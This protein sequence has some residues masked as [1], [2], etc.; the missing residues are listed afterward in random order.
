[1]TLRRRSQKPTREPTIALIN[2]VF[3]MLIFFLIA[4]TVAPPLDP[5]VSL[6]ETVELD[7]RAPPDAAVV[8]EDGTILRD[9]TQIPIEELASSGDVIRLVPDRDLAATALVA[10]SR[11]LR[12][13]GADEVWIVTERGLN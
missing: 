5:R 4:G 11:G 3:L 8:L 10:L 2:V 6:V 7:G 1:M 9:G 12:E 13:A